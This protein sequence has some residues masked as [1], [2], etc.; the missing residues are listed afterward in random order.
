MIGMPP[1]VV[2]GGAPAGAPGAPPPGAPAGA[3]AAAPGFD[4]LFQ[5]LTGRLLV[6]TVGAGVP[7][8]IAAG[9][10]EDGEAA[11]TVSDGEAPQ[12]GSATAATAVVAVPLPMDWTWMQ[13]VAAPDPSPGAT[14]TDGG[15]AGEG[16]HTVTAGPWPSA[17]GAGHL[18]G[19]TPMARGVADGETG[20]ATP[21]GV[22]TGVAFEQ[23]LTLTG[24]APAA[25]APD[26]RAG[27]AS[28]SPAPAAPADLSRIT[29]TPVDV[30]PANQSRQTANAV[31]PPVAAG[32]ANTD[33]LTPANLPTTPD[34][35]T[36]ATP[37][38]TLAPAMADAAPT[39]TTPA[40]SA[41][42]PSAD[43]APIAGATPATPV[44]PSEARPVARRGSER[45]LRLEHASG[46]PTATDAPAADPSR[47]DRGGSADTSAPPVV[48][49]RPVPAGAFAAMERL[50]ATS[51]TPS[52]QTSAANGAV[53]R[54]ES[55]LGAAIVAGASAGTSGSSGDGA[56]ANGRGRENAGFPERAATPVSTFRVLDAPAMPLAAALAERTTSIGE[57][58]APLAEPHLAARELEP[59]LGDAVHGQIVRSIRMQWS[60]G[61]GEARVSLKPE[62]LGEVVASINVE[63]GVVTATLQA[64]TPEVRTWI[65]RN[66]ASLRD[67]L[68]EH[69][70]R[71]DRLEVAEPPP[72]SQTADRQSGRRRQPQAPPPRPRRRDTARDAQTFELTNE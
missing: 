41:A 42:A 33:T 5:Q 28:A 57:P 34:V 45:P 25:P 19:A 3:V 66:A 30:A 54:G 12:D 64:D 62:F 4:A 21:T 35:A 49:R 7:G 60:G 32:P 65:E 46:A 8:R 50:A 44:A 63:R 37:A 29:A 69:G 14:G 6:T 67:A 38:K 43:V 15:D 72:E 59:A 68:G 2:P 58:R 31:V 18:P 55:P 61:L 20:G 51:A 1:S 70:L 48:V 40:P 10:D 23:A 71:L 36:S 22:V 56:N 47:A 53:V 17:P 26:R 9:D 11:S 13:P 16:G 27:D 39:A 24:A 52:G